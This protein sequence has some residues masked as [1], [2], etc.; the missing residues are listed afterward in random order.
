MID[1]KNHI[2]IDDNTIQILDSL[3]Y[4]TAIV[5][6][7]KQVLFMNDIGLKISGFSND[8]LY[9][10]KCYDTFCGAECDHCPVIDLN[11]TSSIS[12][13]KILTKNNNEID[14]LKKVV[15]MQ[16]N[17]E[18]VLLETFTDLSELNK[19]K[20]EIDTSNEKIKALYDNAPDLYVS[21]SPEDGKIINCNQTLLKALGYSRKQVIGLHVFDLYHPKSLDD[22][23]D[24][25]NQFLQTGEVKNKELILKKKDG[26]SV[27][28]SLNVNAIRDNAGNIK[29]SMSSW[30]I[31]DELQE[32]KSK[33]KERVKELNC[34]SQLNTIVS[35]NENSIHDILSKTLE[36]IPESF[37]HPHLTGAQIY[38]DKSEFVSSL[39]NGKQYIIKEN[40]RVE[41]S[42]K[43]Y[44]AVSYESESNQN[45]FLAEEKQLLKNIAS[46]LG[47][48]F[49][50]KNIAR[51]L[52]QS[53]ERFN[54]ASQ[55]LGLA[56]WEFYPQ[57]GLSIGNAE[58]NELFGFADDSGAK[59]EW[60]QY[61]H[62][63]DSA[64]MPSL[65][66]DHL[67]G[68]SDKYDVKFRYNHP[69]SKKEIWIHSSGKVV[70]RDNN[71][72][73]LKMIG[74]SY[75]VTE[76]AR[77]QAV[78][79]EQHAKTLRMFDAIDQVVYITDP[80]TDELLYGNKELNEIWG[81]G[82]SI[83]GQKCY[84]VLQ[85][86]DEPCEFCTNHIIFNEKPGETHIW[87][88]QNIVNKRWYRCYDKAIDWVDGRKVRME[89]AMDITDEKNAQFQLVE[90]EERFRS[91]VDNTS[92]GVVTV[93]HEGYPIF[94]NNSFCR[95]LAYSPDELH[96]M[97]FPEFTHTEDIDKD[98][99]LYI[100]LMNN[101]IPN[102]SI[103]KRYIR[104]D[105]S[106]MWGALTV[107]SV[108]KANGKIKYAV[109]MVDDITD[110]KLT[111]KKI[112]R[113]NEKLKASNEELEQFA[114]VSSHDLQE[115]LRKVK[116]YTELLEVRYED[117]L[118]EKA[119][120][121]MKIII[122]GAERMQTL[123][124][125]LLIISRI[126]TR[127]K[128]FVKTD[129]NKLIDEV[130]DS[131]E[132]PVKESNAE[133]MYDGLPN[134]KVDESQFKMLFQNL[135]SNAVKFRRDVDPVVQIEA[136][137]KKSLWEF[138]VKDN[139]IGFDEQFAERIFVVFQR[140]H[141]RAD[142]KGTGIG[143][144]ICKKIVERHGGKIFAK[145]VQGEGSV[146]TFTIPK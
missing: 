133:I 19:H 65:L 93:S 9:M 81:Q 87:E 21:V 112:L 23:K 104:K 60:I 13:K 5:N 83:I 140:L 78:K 71:G 38:F 141:S 98:L 91:I 144:A 99:D 84:K 3:P 79:N 95:M 31:I 48:N 32:T 145:S 24:A 90:S 46:I 134:V 138:T 139:G 56:F 129:M 124:E 122:S 69:L 43:G 75:D 6:M 15:K 82:G 62:P 137:E 115:P 26:K 22:A 135:I 127:G 34:L 55:S 100:Q 92:I 44:I 30:R 128:E 51:N 25:F 70:E 132:I 17:N 37:L 54:L 41:N 73:A 28:V 4:G 114:Y 53:N 142:Y 18:T 88:F 11:E 50:K 123:I 61:M 96:Q 40:I 16:L 131:L 2:E 94:V 111:E 86:K 130:C 1:T 136:K 36:I 126:T 103:E 74:I 49:T 146:F 110:K 35:D 68:K 101:E 119:K 58:W 76:E 105:G 125:D 14:V 113:M 106:I 102:Y 80:E 64:V 59:N 27:H 109:A 107:S 77:E 143:L 116:N 66:E 67:S 29:Y 85:G 57:S 118:D 121:Y 39:F 12:E 8:E 89:T 97:A 108:K 20:K 63:D 47:E 10:Q 117:Q 7:N 72:K 120:K 42:V 52:K 45:P 33:L